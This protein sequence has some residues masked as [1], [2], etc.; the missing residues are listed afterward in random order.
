MVGEYAVNREGRR[1]GGRGLVVVWE[2][3]LTTNLRKLLHG[4]NPVIGFRSDHSCP[5]TRR[6]AS[7]N[8]LWQSGGYGTH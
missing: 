6:T 5:K 1:G 7:L 3:G 8:R 2:W 4:L